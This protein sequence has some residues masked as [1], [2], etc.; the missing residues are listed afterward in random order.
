MKKST[1]TL[2]GLAIIALAYTAGSWYVGSRI[3]QRSAQSVAQAND[4]LQTHGMPGL[5]LKLETR[6]YERGIFNSEATYVFTYRQEAD[7]EAD[8]DEPVDGTLVLRNHISHGPLAPSALARGQFVPGMA[9]IE[10][11]LVNEGAAAPLFTL[12][13][14]ERPVRGLTRV[15]FDGASHTDWAVAAFESQRDGR[16]VSFSGAQ[17][18]AT[19]EQDLKTV[20]ASGGMDRLLYEAAGESAEINDVR[21]AA[22]T[23]AGKHGLGVGDSSFTVG[24]IKLQ[25][26][27]A[28]AIALEKFAHRVELFE[29]DKT[30]GFN[31][32]YAVD[33]IAI[34]QHDFGNMEIGI[35][36][37][38]I[39]AVALQ[40]FSKRYDDLMRE[41]AATNDQVYSGATLEAFEAALDKLLAGKPVAAIDPWI[42]KT[43][44]GESRLSLTAHLRETT[45]PEGSVSALPELHMLEKL[46][47]D[48]SV[49]KPM[50]RQIMA[51]IL[52]SQGLGEGE[53][54]NM[55]AQ[56]QVDAMAQ[57]AQATGYV[58]AEGENLSIELQYADGKLTLNGKEQAVEDM[59]PGLGLALPGMGMDDEMDE[60]GGYDGQVA[61]ANVLGWLD[62][63]EIAALFEQEGYAVNVTRDFADEPFLEISGT[64][65]RPLE[66]RRMEVEFY[67]C[68]SDSECEDMLL[69]SAHDPKQWVTLEMLNAWNLDSRWAKAF[70]TEDGETMLEMDVNAYG[71]LGIDNLD[72]LLLTFLDLAQEFAESIGAPS[73]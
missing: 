72:A 46:D 37:D 10:S 21:M 71:G 73:N 60:A 1:V 59:M 19:V 16:S 17:I 23:Q 69:R 63:R 57:A 22:N 2:A 64:P 36:A 42:W 70:K 51:A 39:D 28:Q 26:P 58:V 29:G 62:P 3:E 18:S 68:R 50:V 35:K 20:T 48:L 11:T 41:S 40:E 13:G 43:P 49:A 30:V 67:N 34:A 52:Q 54:A 61:G 56:S 4:T 31:A 65:E 44:E 7:P 24:L 6:S 55:M 38:N 33:R 45:P 25:P 8:I 5:T 47:L 15:A 66:G 27:G 12:T 53:A 14:N 32:H 9:H